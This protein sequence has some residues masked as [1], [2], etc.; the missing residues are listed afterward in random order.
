MDFARIKQDFTNLILSRYFKGRVI[1]ENDEYIIIETDIKAKSLEFIF[2]ILEMQK[3]LIEEEKSKSFKIQQ[4]IG[5]PQL[6]DEYSAFIGKYKCDSYVIYN[7]REYRITKNDKVVYKSL[8][9]TCFRLIQEINKKIYI[10]FIES[11]IPG[12]S[13]CNMSRYIVYYINNNIY[14]EIDSTF[15][16]NWEQIYNAFHTVHKICTTFNDIEIIQLPTGCYTNRKNNRITNY[17][18]MIQVGK[19]IIN[20]YPFIKIDSE[21]IIKGTINSEGIL[22]TINGI[23][24]YDDPELE[25]YK[26]QNKIARNE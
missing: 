24:L 2:M 1:C 15:Y 9:L 4:I 25:I 7:T 14:Y 21:L 26:F 20:R 17:I 23:S 5:P 11:I 8:R 22:V 6:P 16:Y 3:I 19:F 12:Y 13:F 10:K 18:G